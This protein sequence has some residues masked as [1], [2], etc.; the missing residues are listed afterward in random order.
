MAPRAAEQTG[1]RAMAGRAQQHFAAQPD[2]ARAGIVAVMADLA[3]EG[4]TEDMLH[5]VEIVLAEAV[6]NVVEHA[7]AGRST[8][9]VQV[10]CYLS[11][12]RLTIHVT[13]NGRAFPGDRLPPGRPANVDGPR[14][15]LPEGGFGWL[16]IR[17]LASHVDYRRLGTTN[18]LTIDF[19]V[20]PRAE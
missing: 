17:K 1:A 18:T 2:A 12:D 10:D 15:T 7:Y 16:L 19:D 3:S 9:E 13:D 4:L 5:R 11:P 20:P 14:D 8:G 6:N